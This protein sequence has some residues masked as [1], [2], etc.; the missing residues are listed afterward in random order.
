MSTISLMPINKKIKLTKDYKFV[1]ESNNYLGDS[2]TILKEAGIAV[3]KELIL[4]EGSKIR[5][6]GFS[7]SVTDKD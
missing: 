4:D 1:M 3:G 7:S 5:V 6:E 2:H